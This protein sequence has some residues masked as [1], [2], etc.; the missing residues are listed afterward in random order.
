MERP[1]TAA[2]TGALAKHARVNYAELC[3]RWKALRSRDDLT[4]REVACVGAP[5]TLL[6][7][8][9]GDVHKP[10][11]AISAGTHGDEPAGVH[12]LVEAVERGDLDPR[13]SYRLWPC[14]NPT[15]FDRATRENA[16]GVD[17]NRTF[18]RG[19]Q[20]PEASAIVMSNRN[21]KFALALDLHE[22]DEAAGFYCYAYGDAPGERVVATLASNG[23]A[24]D[25]RGCLR[26]DP[27]AEAEEIGGL[28]YALLLVRNASPRALTFETPSGRALDERIAMQRAAIAAALSDFSQMIV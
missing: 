5:R 13:F 14:V 23:I 6:S 12:A 8:E 9:I 18:G 26:P 15:G 10:A 22:D 20:S 2:T 24:I 16:D 17:V 21:R 28:S 1:V 11:I 25:P 4:V 19:G 27:H 3:A 7:V